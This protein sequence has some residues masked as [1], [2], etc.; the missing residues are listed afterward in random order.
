MLQQQLNITFDRMSVILPEIEKKTLQSGAMSLKEKVKS[1]FISKL[2]AAANLLRRV[3]NNYQNTPLV[4]GVRQSKVDEK[5]NSVKVHILGT[6]GQ[7]M[8][9]MTRFFEYQ[10]KE[11]Y[12]KTRNGK[13]LKKPRYTKYLPGYHFFQPTVD[14]EIQNTMDHMGRVYENKIKKIVN[15]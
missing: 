13:K 12:N 5:T 15:E 4:E 8:T 1:A 14:A 10:T 7:D 11:R 6:H 2:P 9:W 3:V